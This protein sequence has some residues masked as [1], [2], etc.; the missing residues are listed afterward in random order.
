MSVLTPL[1]ADKLLLEQ[2]HGV[3]SINSLFRF[4]LDMVSPSETPVVFD[5]ILGQ[6]VTVS[7]VLES[8]AKRYFNGICRRFVET[9]MLRGPHLAQPI[10]TYQAEIVPKLWELT[11]K[12]NTRLWQ[13]KS[14]KDII[15]EVL[16]SVAHTLKLTATYE[17]RDYCVQF[18]ETDFD[19]IS[20]LME[21]EGIFYFFEHADGSH[22]M[23]IGDDATAHSDIVEPSEVIFR[24]PGQEGG[25]AAESQ[26]RIQIW[27]KAQELRSG[28]T[29]LWDHKFEMTG[30]NFESIEQILPTAQAG[31]ISH[32]LNVAES[33]SW[34]RYLFPGRFA[35]RF[36]GITPAGGEQPSM[37]SKIPPDG[38]RTVKLRQEQE[39]SPAVRV[40]GVSSVRAFA[41]GA[42]FNLIEHFDANGAYKIVQVQHQAS[43]EGAYTGARGAIPFRYANSFECMP[44]AVPYRPAMT[45]PRPIVEGPQTATVVGTPGKE[46]FT[47]KYGRIKVQ[48]HW[49]RLNTKNEKSSCWLRVATLWSG[50]QWGSVFIPR[51][52]QEVIVAFLDGDPDRPICVGGVYN[53]QQM[54]PYTLPD[55]ETI[56]GIKTNSSLGGSGFNEIRFQD[57]ASSEEIYIHA[58]KDMNKVIENDHTEHIKH[59]MLLH[60]VNER[61]EMVD[62]DSHL[63]L[64]NNHKE[65][66]DVN[67]DQTVGGD[68]KVSVTGANHLEV[69]GAHNE[70]TTGDHSLTCDAQYILDATGN[71]TVK[72]AGTVI[73]DAPTIVV[74]G[75][76][77]VS[78]VVGGNFVKVSSMG[79]DI[80]GTMVKINSGGAA[81][82]GM[83]GTATAPTAAEAPTDPVM[84]TITP[85]A[86]TGY[87]S[88]E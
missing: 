55:H 77:G 34:E 7:L 10:I 24:R 71:V 15:V 53:D 50:K 67:F 38:T 52:G 16:G 12:V 85:E 68:K 82:Q 2:F 37:L 45:T 40:T 59:D 26:E 4:N 25:G 65:K 56:S 84:P 19:F 33:S 21:E 51:V 13:E 61:K 60:V 62:M 43:L 66:I 42:K 18:D 9:G 75:S 23:I 6:S 58:Q 76:T 72:S 81:D 47:D 78:L 36:D 31:T 44:D 14:V 17:P 29:T 3:E 87:K 30:K 5:Q 8:G 69:T 35:K 1:G 39:T 27:L 46:I 28:K 41:A 20:R 74:K 22:T 49:D 32:K 11:R 54:P 80:V 70:K 57:K 88:C 48:F 63:H 73:I 64:K 86:I 79:V 83:A